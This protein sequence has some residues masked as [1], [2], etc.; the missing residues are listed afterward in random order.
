MLRILSLERNYWSLAPE[1]NREEP[2]GE[3]FG[4]SRSEWRSEE[5]ISENVSI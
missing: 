3:V 5:F 4:Y 2:K 1:A